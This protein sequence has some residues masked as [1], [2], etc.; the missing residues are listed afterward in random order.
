MSHSKYEIDSTYVYKFYRMDEYY[1]YYLENGTDEEE[2]N[3]LEEDDGKEVNLG[4]LRRFLNGRIHVEGEFD[5]EDWFYE[6]PDDAPAP[7]EDE[8]FRPLVL[9]AAAKAALIASRA[10]KFWP[11]YL[12]DSYVALFLAASA[13]SVD[14]VKSH[15]EAGVDVNAVDQD[16]LSAV[17]VAAACGHDPVVDVLVNAQAD[18][19][20]TQIDLTS[21]TEGLPDHQSFNGIESIR[22]AMSHV[23]EVVNGMTMLQ[24][25]VHTRDIAIVK[26]VLLAG[27]DLASTSRNQPSPLALACDMAAKDI[28]GEKMLQ[29][30]LSVHD[31]TDW[32]ESLEFL[33]HHA[34]M[35]DLHRVIPTLVAAK[36]D[37]NAHGHASVS[38]REQWR[39][40]KQTLSR[41]CSPRARVLTP[42]RSLRPLKR[43]CCWWLQDHATSK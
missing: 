11:V 33:V 40:A 13:G 5:D 2:D 30:L 10:A 34:I 12:Q 32:R 42:T 6:G 43:V 18:V 22:H 4:G 28:S 31:P 21:L 38:L 14:Q 3:F 41:R 20:R 8:S 26:L 16:G 35:N 36:A 7:E 24:R 15:I 29:L 19:N 23:G 27:A 17:M 9:T 37:V 25:A 1:Q 39:W